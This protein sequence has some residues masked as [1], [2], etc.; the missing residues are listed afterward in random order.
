M[1][2][3]VNTRALSESPPPQ[4]PTRHPRPRAH[5]RGPWLGRALAVSRASR[6]WR[7]ETGRARWHAPWPRAARAP[8]A[9]CGLAQTNMGETDS[10]SDT[11][12]AVVACAQSLVSTRCTCYTSRKGKETLS[13]LRDSDAHSPRGSSWLSTYKVSLYRTTTIQRTNHIL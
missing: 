3:E 5:R 4:R 2:V 8:T 10:Y 1:G 11:C 6:R 13:S 12:K 7:V 9:E